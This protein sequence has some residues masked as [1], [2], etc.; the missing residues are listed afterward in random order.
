MYEVD[1]S[2]RH[3]YRNLIR[4][5]NYS[6]KVKSRR[7]SCIVVLLAL[8]ATLAVAQ[9]PNVQP[10][11]I[12]SAWLANEIAVAEQL[13]ASLRA[14]ADRFDSETWIGT[15]YNEIG[16]PT[17]KCYAL[18]VLLG[19][20]RNV[21][22]LQFD[23][24]PAPV[25]RSSVHAHELRVRARYLDNFVSAAAFVLKMSEGQRSIAWDLDCSGQYGIVHTPAPQPGAPTFF[26]VVQ[27]GQVLRILG[28]IEPGFVDALTAVLAEYPSVSFVALGS[29]GGSVSEAL[30]AGRLIRAKQL[31]TTLWNNC[32][33]A[34]PLVFVGGA[35]RLIWS[36]YPYLGF[37]QIYTS[38]GPIPL[39]SP[40]YAYVAAYLREMGI[41]DLF[42][43]SAM[44]QAAPTEMNMISGVDERLCQARVATWIQ[45]LCSADW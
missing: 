24:S 32:F 18:G 43:I 30:A 2:P 36:P 7:L 8:L 13:A 33:S 12:P 9:Q 11:V 6:A 39:D 29:G 38:Q 15:M 19:F 37:H 31:T 26:D 40:V 5:V 35:E 14:S 17:H 42:V 25:A 23:R 1:S 3:P 20:E 27:E 22:H 21:H 34:C 4:Q 16:L 45:R 10:P 41:D 44:A 28:A